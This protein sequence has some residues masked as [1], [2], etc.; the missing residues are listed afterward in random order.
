MEQGHKVKAPVQVGAWDLAVE[1]AGMEQALAEIA[2][3][4]TVGKE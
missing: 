3:A 4:R 1:A 2:F